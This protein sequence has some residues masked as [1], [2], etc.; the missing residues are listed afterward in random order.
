M[1]GRTTGGAAA[2]TCIKDTFPIKL[3]TYFSL[4]EFIQ[5]GAPEDMEPGTGMKS[6]QCFDWLADSG[7]NLVTGNRLFP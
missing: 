6:F 7:A 5:H 1:R 3:T 2:Y 4:S